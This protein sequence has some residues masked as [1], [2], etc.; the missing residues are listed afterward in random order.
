MSACAHTP[1]CA[2]VHAH[3]VCIKCAF[4]HHP[5]IELDKIPFSR[6]HSQSVRVY[7]DAFLCKHDKHLPPTA[8]LRNQERSRFPAREHTFRS[9]LGHQIGELL[10]QRLFARTESPSKKSTNSLK[11]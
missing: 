9:R 7:P 2:R 11:V 3:L 6:M 10:S 4:L 1:A 8:T 5:S